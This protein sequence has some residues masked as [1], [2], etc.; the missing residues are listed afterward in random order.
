MHTNSGTQALALMHQRGTQAH[1]LRGTEAQAL[2]HSG[3]STQALAHTHTRRQPIFGKGGQIVHLP[4]R[5]ENI[6]SGMPLATV[7]CG[8]LF[9]RLPL[10]SQISK[11]SAKIQNFHPNSRI[12]DGKMKVNEWCTRS[13]KS[14]VCNIYE[15]HSSWGYACVRKSYSPLSVANKGLSSCG[16]PLALIVAVRQFF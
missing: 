5:A 14:F 15:W 7:V 1:A 2:R 6:F 4:S 12:L 11:N 9:D 8:I 3:T 13:A 10:V 16:M